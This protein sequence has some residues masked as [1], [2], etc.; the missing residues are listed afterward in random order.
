[1]KKEGTLKQDILKL[2]VYADVDLYGLLK[3][4]DNL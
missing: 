2:G 3:S 4:N 1:M